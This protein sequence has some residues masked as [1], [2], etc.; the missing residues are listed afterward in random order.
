[1]AAALLVMAPLTPTAHGM[2]GA[3]NLTVKIVK[4]IACQSPFLKEGS[5]L[6]SEVHRLANSERGQLSHLTYGAS[7]FS[8]GGTAVTPG[9]AIIEVSAEC[10]SWLTETWN[11]RLDA[12]SQ[13]YT[14]TH[15]VSAAQ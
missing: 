15:N 2:D 11:A 12:T 14:V 7:K 4:N 5:L 8:D 10:S 6:G 13:A 9:A 3:A 1:M